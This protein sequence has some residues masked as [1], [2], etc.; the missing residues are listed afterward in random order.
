[1]ELDVGFGYASAAC[2]SDILFLETILELKGEIHLVLPYPAAQ[3]REDCVDIIP[4]SNWG[5]R[6]AR[7][8]ERATEVSVACNC[9]YEEN[10]SLYQYTHR[11]LHGLAKMRSQQLDTELIPLV[12]WDGQPGDSLGG[13]AT[14]VATWQQWG[15]Q[16]EIINPQSLT[17]VSVAAPILG[18][19]S[20]P[21]IQTDER[22]RPIMA[23]LFADVVRFSRLTEEQI[24]PYVEHFLTAIAD[25]EVNS[26]Y[27]PAMKNTWGD[28]LYYVFPQVAEAGNF[29]LDL[30]DLLQRIDWSS[31]G[32]PEEL[33]LRISL[34]AGPVYSY[35]NP[36]T[37]RTSYSGTHVSYAA[38]IEPITPPRK[39]YASQEFAAVV[40]AENVQDF[41]CDYVGQTPLAKGYGT[42]P[43]Y[44]VHR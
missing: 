6:F 29:A 32:L 15:Y 8:L 14:M 3:F 16:V 11:L 23:L 26:G 27:Q 12:V 25:L 39:V 33:S 13:T 37:K 44:H 20:K 42:F 1:L 31:K 41:A 10:T 17:S 28:A 18:P 43:T 35:T 22:C 38:R 4:E 30:C 21:A 2:G 9:R 19:N 40:C 34:H 36:I 5:E 24:I 7:L